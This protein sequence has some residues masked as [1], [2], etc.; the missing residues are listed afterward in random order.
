MCSR[1]LFI[2]GRES[3]ARSLSRMLH[4]LPLA[5]DHVP[6]LQQARNMLNQRDYDVILTEA[7]LHRRQLAPTSLHL[8][9][10][11]QPGARGHR[12]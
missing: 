6:T 11:L 7:T 2:S 1:V 10:V 12:H 4:Q 3:D 5:M 9:R 8:V